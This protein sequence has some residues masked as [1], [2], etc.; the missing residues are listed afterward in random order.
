M[1][2]GVTSRWHTKKLPQETHNGL[3]KVVCIGAWHPSRTQGQKGEEYFQPYLQTLELG[4]FLNTVS[5]VEAL[6]EQFPIAF[7]IFQPM[8]I[9]TS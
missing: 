9:P 3:R 2:P 8:I 1:F 6:L 5:S 4:S 7:M